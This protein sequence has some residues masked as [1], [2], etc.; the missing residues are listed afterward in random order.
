MLR[1]IKKIL[2]PFY[3]LIKYRFND[4]KRT[5]YHQYFPLKPS[6][7][8]LNANDICNS[9]CTMC[10]IW[11]QK[12]DFEITP[13]NLSNILQDKL[14]AE[15]R[16][17]G[18][19]GGEPTLREDL[20]VL[21]EACATSLPNLQGLSIITN[22]IKSKDVIKRVE[23]VYEICKK[24]HKSFSMMVSLDGYGET[25][26]Q[27]RGRQGNFA[28][29]MEVINHFRTHTN[30]EIAIGCT[31]SKVNVWEVDVLLEF[32]RE[33]N[34]YGRFRVAEHINRLYNGD[35]GD[36]IRN[37]DE[38]EQYHLACF[39][40]KL[41]LTYETNE[42]YQRTYKNII[43][44]L[45]GAKRQIACPYH[46]KGVVLDSRGDVHYCAPKSKKLGNTL[47][48]SALRLFNGNLSERRRILK[49]NCDSCIHD[50]HAPITYQEQLD[51]Y[52]SIFWKEWFTIQNIAKAKYLN[53][54]L[55]FASK[56]VG[57][58][59]NVY[60]VGWYGTET[61]G[62][63][64]ILGQILDFYKEKYADV[65]FYIASLYPFVTE[66]TIRELEVEATVVPCDA[67]DFARYAAQCDEVVMGGGPLMDMEAL[68]V[69]LWA[70]KVAKMYH[71]KTV[72]FG[73]GL[74][75]LHSEKYIDAVKQILL[76]SDE[77]KLR[78][79]KS[80]LYAQEL[81]GRQDIVNSGDGAYAYVSK[82]DKQI[83]V[84][85]QKPVLACFLREWSTEYKGTLS[86]TEFFEI[87]DK[88]EANI[89][90]LIKQ[91]CKEN[92]VKPAFYPMH[93]FTVGGDD[94]EFYRRFIKKHFDG[95]DYFFYNKNAQVRTTIEA[96]KTAKYNLCMRFHSV[97]FAHTL[98]TN[99]MAID[100]TQGGKIHNFLSDNQDLDRL[101]DL[102][103]LAHSTPE[104]MQRF[105]T[106]IFKLHS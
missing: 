80:V 102:K 25:H 28:S 48:E 44:M 43:G 62:D 17:V 67:F 45:G 9:K 66:K 81:T 16:H 6:V 106:S 78:D 87:R 72:V 77:V 47:K 69:P 55:P 35:R 27:V 99:F 30:I 63:K 21:Y 104:D 2:K 58:G 103:M 82:L 46:A 76:L 73:C 38:E 36:V 29:A 5:F 34:L 33:Q 90:F 85:E 40:K 60:I 94:R 56:W 93:T 10:N 14:F 7:I 39:F 88:F 51:K 1:I 3:Y 86:E 91:F 4:W 18:I 11:Q 64:A 57:K 79:N 89:A 59:K 75:P 31:I 41:E 12:Q 96:M 19:T 15:I 68:A 105:T 95:K 22:A 50:Y 70:F 23:K 83:T 52:K 97:L 20:P 53:F 65:N 84:T 24:H 98:R 101:L 8:N 49:E 32:L 61:V 13:E 26:E 100:Y 42:T 71:K 54:L 37:F 74:G 92:G